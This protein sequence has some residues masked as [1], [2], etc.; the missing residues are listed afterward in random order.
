M[1]GWMRI[2]VV[3]SAVFLLIGTAAS[4]ATY[5]SDS[6]WFPACRAAIDSGDWSRGGGFQGSCW[7]SVANAASAEAARAAL[8]SRAR[9]LVANSVEGAL[10]T[11]LMP[12]ALLGALFLAVGWIR[13]GFHRPAAR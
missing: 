11:W 12:S 2:W 10:I 4:V 6:A 3:L 7:P 1:N 9:G 8:D 5:R 13:R